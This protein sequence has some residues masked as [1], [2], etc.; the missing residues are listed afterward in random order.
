ML[1][2]VAVGVALAVAVGALTFRF[3]SPAGGEENSAPANSDAARATGSNGSQDTNAVPSP[4][5][6]SSS[7]PT[8]P[9]SFVTEERALKESLNAWVAATNSRDVSRQMEFYM[10]RLTSYYRTSNASRENVMRDKRAVFEQ[11]RSV[12]ISVGEPVVRFS[13]DGGTAQMSFTKEYEIARGD[14]SSSGAVVQELVWQKTADGWRIV[15]ERD[16][17]VLR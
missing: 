12:R 17:R 4:T 14:G 1:A 2:L 5:T 9:P 13:P 3:L 8:A 15:S 16:A 6:Q 11:A 10:P 7:G